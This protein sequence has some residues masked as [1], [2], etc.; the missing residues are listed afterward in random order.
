MGLEDTSRSSRFFLPGIYASGFG[1]KALG[2]RVS[3][4]RYQGV[5]FGVSLSVN[6]CVKARISSRVLL[7]RAGS[8]QVKNC[9]F[10]VYI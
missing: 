3:G 2:I 4:F 7:L 1:V 10:T 9:G 8:H 5:E 6:L